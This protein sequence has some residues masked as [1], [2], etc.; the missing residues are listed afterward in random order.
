MSL[1]GHLQGFYIVIDQGG[2]GGR[3]KSFVGHPARLPGGHVGPI[4]EIQ[5]GQVIE[6]QDVRLN[7]VG[8]KTKLRMIRALAGTV[9]L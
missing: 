3:I 4:D 7:E 9:T 1:A 5:H 8:P 6:M 2:R